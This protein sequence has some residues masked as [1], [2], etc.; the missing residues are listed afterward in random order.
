MG[1]N[2]NEL[3][4]DRILSGGSSIGNNPKRMS[5]SGS[6]QVGGGLSKRTPPGG[7]NCDNNLDKYLKEG[8]GR[9]Y[10]MLQ[11]LDTYGFKKK[12]EE[13]KKEFFEKYP[14]NDYSRAKYNQHAKMSSRRT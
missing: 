4:V 11:M 5:T 6:A 12:A 14:E 10:D 8:Q 7:L 2:P 3:G 9:I 13:A 1:E